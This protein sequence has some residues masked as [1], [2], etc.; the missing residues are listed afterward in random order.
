MIL[1]FYSEVGTRFNVGS[2]EIHP[3]GLVQAAVVQNKEVHFAFFLDLTILYQ[4]KS[5]AFIGNNFP[6]VFFFLRI[7]YLIKGMRLIMGEEIIH[8]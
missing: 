7:S 8:I 6:W 5:K 4:K 1:T 3:T 2:L